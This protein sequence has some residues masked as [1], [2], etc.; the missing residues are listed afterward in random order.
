MR[1]E[2]ILFTD[3]LI[4]I[5]KNPIVKANIPNLFIKGDD[6]IIDVAYK[7]KKL[8]FFFD[9]GNSNTSFYKNM[10]DIDSMNFKVL[11]DTVFSYASVGGTITQKAKLLPRIKL[12]CGSKSF[13]L[14][15]TYIA[16]KKNILNPDLYGSIGKDF[17]NQYKSI[18]MCFKYAY[19]DF[20]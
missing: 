4:Y 3:S 19:I 14:D 13:V 12:D 5:P 8:P 15:N 20:E 17:V 11:K 6:Y 16:L 2:S 1:F 9:T 7:N 18:L 10:Y